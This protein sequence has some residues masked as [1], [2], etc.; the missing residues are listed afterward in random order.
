[1]AVVFIPTLLQDLT[2]GLSKIEASG[3]TIRDLIAALDQLH[4][5]LAARLTEDDRL[6]PNISV[7]VD[8]EISP[9]GLL[10]KVSPTSEVH[11]LTAIKGGRQSCEE[12]CL[13]G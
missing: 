2:G 1:V 11:F 4:P 6:R 10:E 7:A 13:S 3:A 5:G 9:L 12:D 8:G